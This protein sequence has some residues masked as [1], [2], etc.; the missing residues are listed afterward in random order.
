MKKLIPI[1]LALLALLC[2]CG[3]SAVSGPTVNAVVT[4]RCDTVVGQADYIPADGVMLPE[5]E[6]AVPEGASAYDLF[7]AAAKSAKLA[8]VNGGSEQA[9]YITGIGGLSAGE[10]GDLS[11]WLLYINGEMAV[12]NCKAII[13]GEGDR[14]DF[15]YSCDFGADIEAL[16]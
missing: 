6:L 4:V 14:V 10:F 3:K 1:V 13:L 2:S 16:Q 7:M 11:G 15:L 12:A 8:V 5:T 9:P